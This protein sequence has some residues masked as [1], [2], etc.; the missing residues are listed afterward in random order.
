MCYRIFEFSYFEKALTST[1]MII[2]LA[3]KEKKPYWQSVGFFNKANILRIQGNLTD[4]ISNYDKSLSKMNTIPKQLKHLTRILISK[5]QILKDQGLLV[6]SYNVLI[7]ALNFGEELKDPF[8]IAQIHNSL[9]NTQNKFGNLDE[10]ENHFKQAI[11]LFEKLNFLIG[12]A[13]VYLSWSIVERY[14]GKYKEELE[15]LQLAT[16]ICKELHSDFYYCSCLKELGNYYSNMENYKM[17]L[18]YYNKALAIALKLKDNQSRAEL[19]GSIGRVFLRRGDTHQSSEKINKA[20]LI[21]EKYGY[22]QGKAVNLENI[23]RID[24]IN[25][26]FISAISNIKQAI[27][28][29]KKIGNFQKTVIGYINLGN[30]Y[31]LQGKSKIALNSYHEASEMIEIVDNPKVVAEYHIKLA[32]VWIDL[33]KFDEAIKELKSAETISEKLPKKN[34]DIYSCYGLI[35]ELKGN[36]KKAIF[37]YKKSLELTQKYEL[38]REIAIKLNK[39]GLLYKKLENFERSL[40]HYEKALQIALEL[41]DFHGIV[42]TLYNIGYIQNKKGE[43]KLALENLIEAHKIIMEQEI[44]DKDLQNKINKAILVVKRNLKS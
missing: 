37:F 39:L 27:E 7:K 43:H 18:E 41:E 21:N 28:I 29:N 12:K 32:K 23:A 9:G 42:I 24:E 38:K 44:N 4:A 30:A 17:A 33:K 11:S 20:L 16:K 2:D 31:Q 26:D 6:E 5:A 3:I 25:G 34:I 35:R 14:K 15:L 19:L 10:S 13:V 36:P 1:E 40:E 8:L 22:L